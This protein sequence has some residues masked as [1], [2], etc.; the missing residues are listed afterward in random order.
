M[1]SINWTDQK[2]IFSTNGFSAWKPR[3]S[4]NVAL[5]SKLAQTIMEFGISMLDYP[6]S[7]ES[8]LESEGTLGGFPS[9]VKIFTRFWSV[10]ATQIFMWAVIALCSFK[11]RYIIVELVFTIW[12]VYSYHLWFLIFVTED[13]QKRKEH[14]DT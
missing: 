10:F 14:M 2:K 7:T 4:K 5:K 8:Q 13:K 9:L 12:T 11:S 1:Y 6:Q 3:C